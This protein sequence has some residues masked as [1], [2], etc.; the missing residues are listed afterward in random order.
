MTNYIQKG[1]T[2]TVTAPCDVVSGGG[3]LVGSIFGVASNDAKSGATDLEIDTEGVY[4]LP[5]AAGA[6]TQGEL[7]YWDDTNKVV[8]TTALNNTKIGAA[9]QAAAAGDATAR[10]RLNGA[11]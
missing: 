5:K 1:E 9:T 2:I 11:F 6:V 4:D 8:T 10:V 3:V 7:I